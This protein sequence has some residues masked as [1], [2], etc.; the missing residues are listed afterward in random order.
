M[1]V[2]HSL[3][4]GFLLDPVENLG[5]LVIEASALFHQVSYLLVGIHNSCVVAVSKQ[6]A[7]FGQRKVG[8]LADQIHGN[9]AGLGNS[10]LPGGAK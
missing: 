5:D 8:L 10:L 7:D 1:E 2:I 9:L 3:S 6:L 4:T